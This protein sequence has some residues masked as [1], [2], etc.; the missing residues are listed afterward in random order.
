MSIG[1]KL[2]D[3]GMRTHGGTQWEIG[4]KR[5]TNGAGALCGPGWLHY[6]SHPGLAVM[7][8]PIHA[9]IQRPRLFRCAIGGVQQ[10]DRGLKSGTTELTL[11]CEMKLPVITVEQR[12]RFAILCAKRVC[13]EPA[14]AAW[15]DHWLDG[16]DRGLDAAAAAASSARAEMAAAYAADAA[17]Y[18]ADADFDLIKIIEEEL[19][20]APIE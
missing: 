6:Y 9:K 17:A 18:A 20:N 2:T 4:V 19:S 5:A 12:V 10:S 15:A 7:L 11:L 14:W 8:N 1:Y 13:N 16:S 3:S